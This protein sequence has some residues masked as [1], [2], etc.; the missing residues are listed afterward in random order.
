[1]KHLR[2]LGALLLVLAFLAMTVVIL[3]PSTA[4]EAMFELG[5]VEAVDLAVPAYVADIMAEA[6]VGSVEAVDTL[7]E[8]PVTMATLALALIVSYT[9]L[10]QGAFWTSSASSTID[11]R[12]RPRDGV[13]PAPSGA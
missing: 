12:R 8:I 5:I 7:L 4:P 3:T 9:L 11:G 6:D 2:I 13:Q 1:M 10:K